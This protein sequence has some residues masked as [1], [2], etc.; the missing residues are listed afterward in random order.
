MNRGHLVAR[1]GFKQKIVFAFLTGIATTG[2]VSFTVV[3][4][5]M[6]LTETFWKIWVKSWVLAQLVAFPVI[7]IVSPLIRRFVDFLFSRSAARQK[8]EN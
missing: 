3:L 6:G 1:N 2:T 8:G 5:N 4:I 7:L